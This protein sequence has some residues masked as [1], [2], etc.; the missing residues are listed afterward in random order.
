MREAK[1]Q[2]KDSFDQ[3]FCGPIGTPQSLFPSP[4][5]LL[6]SSPFA[7]LCRGGK[8]QLRKCVRGEKR[9]GNVN[10]RGRRPLFLSRRNVGEFLF[11]YAGRS[12]GSLVELFASAI[13]K[14]RWK[15]NGRTILHALFFIFSSSLSLSYGG[16]FRQQTES[17]ELHACTCRDYCDDDRS[18]LRFLKELECKVWTWE[19]GK[20][21]LKER[22]EALGM[23]LSGF[24]YISRFVMDVIKFSPLDQARS[25]AGERRA[26]RAFF[27]FSSC[28]HE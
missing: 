10:E 8:R 18:Y 24:A 4:F 5:P 27:P 14:G 23:P 20:S 21:Q 16:F 2:K 12:F 11:T 7:F 22:K 3:S 28:E 25:T 1:K 17:E 13:R 9:R 15:G 6:L 26:S 19:F